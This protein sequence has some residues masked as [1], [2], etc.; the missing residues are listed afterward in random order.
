MWVSMKVGVISNLPEAEYNK[1]KL[2]AGVLQPA[3]WEW[4]VRLKL[5]LPAIGTLP[6]QVPGG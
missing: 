6:Y 3:L 5:V 4:M 2:L 1:E